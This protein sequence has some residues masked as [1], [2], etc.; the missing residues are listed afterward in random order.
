MSTSK[1]I[2]LFDILDVASELALDGDDVT[3]WVNEFGSAPA[4][5]RIDTADGF[6][7]FE[8]QLVSLD[9]DGCFHADSVKGVSVT[10]E[11][12]ISR[13]VTYEDV[14]KALPDQIKGASDV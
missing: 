1:L 11:A 6:H 12:K 8:D 5:Y 3:E 14:L 9:Q 4:T 13:P 2:N 7:R 10:I